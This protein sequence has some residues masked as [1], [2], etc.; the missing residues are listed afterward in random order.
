MEFIFNIGLIAEATR[1]IAV[2]VALQV[3]ISNDFLICEHAV[4]ESDTEPTLVVRVIY[5]NNSPLFFLQDTRDAA[6]YLE[7]DCIAVYRPKT[8]KGA[9]VGPRAE[10]WGTF[11]PELFFMLDGTRLAGGVSK[12]A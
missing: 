12:A 4:V 5:R 11:N 7:Q 3:L 10:K 6:S 2:E 9:L 1:S 8:G